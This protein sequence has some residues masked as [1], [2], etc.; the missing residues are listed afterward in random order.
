MQNILYHMA[1]ISIFI[2][3]VLSSAW[4][5][6]VTYQSTMTSTPEEEEILD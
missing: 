4:V 2:A 3:F 1:L 6:I 5:G